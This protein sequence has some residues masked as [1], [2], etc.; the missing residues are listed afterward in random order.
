[1]TADAVNGLHVNGRRLR[2]ERLHDE[3]CG[4][5]GESVMPAELIARE[6][7]HAHVFEFDG[8]VIGRLVWVATRDDPYDVAGWW[9]DLPGGKHKLLYEAPNDPCAD[10]EVVRRANEPMCLGLAD[11]VM[12]DWASGLL[13]ALPGWPPADA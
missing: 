7:D 2:G 10:L 13:E 9:L 1:M 4:R 3:N 5:R 6:V 8:R 11:A 12:G